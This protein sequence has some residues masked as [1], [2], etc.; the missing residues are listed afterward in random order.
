M[1]NLLIRILGHFATVIFG[2]A[3]VLDRWFWLRK[4]LRS[5][6]LR[7]LDAG[8]GSG[9]F[10]LYATKRGNNV[11]GI[12]FDESNNVK[13]RVRAD[14]LKLKNVQFIQGDLR[15]LDSIAGDLGQFDQI[16]CFET[17]EHI[18]ND[19]KLLHDLVGM[20]VVGGQILITAPYIKHVR[21][22]NESIS[23]IENGGHV[24][25]GYSHE[26]LGDILKNEGTQIVKSDY[27]SG[28]VSQHIIRAERF[29]SGYLPA[30]IAWLIIF[31]L[32]F[33]QL[34]DKPVT[35]ILKYP[36]LSVGIVAKKI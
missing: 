6:Y 22:A 36:H 11:T 8:C 3:A 7:T 2:D 35:M 29:V 26:E 18:I 33:F 14:V 13:A 24:R 1:D 12:S 31:P 23:Q 27:V 16:I 30:K 32:R 28:F 10:S 15:K 34:V 9:S 21:M 19:K 17:I 25:W 4:Y 20:L 5:G